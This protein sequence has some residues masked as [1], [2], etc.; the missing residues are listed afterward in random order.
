M[1]VIRAIKIGAGGRKQIPDHWVSPTSLR[2][3]ILKDPCLL[4]LKYHGRQYGFEEDPQEGSLMEYI[5]RQGQLFE[6]KWLREL[7]PEAVAASESDVAVRRFGSLMKTVELMARRIPVITKAAVWNA[8]HGVYGCQDMI[9]LASWLRK[10]FPDIASHL[11]D[12]NKDC[13]HVLDMKN[14]RG[15]DKTSGATNLKL[16]ATQIGIYTRAIGELQGVVPTHAFL[17]TPDHLFSPLPVLVGGGLGDPLPAEIAD[18]IRLHNHI[19]KHGGQ[20]RPWHDEIVAPN[21]R[22]RN[23]EAPWSGAKKK[24]LSEHMDHRPL[25]LLPGVGR[26]QAEA[27]REAGFRS[28]DDLLKRSAR[29]FDFTT[30]PGFKDAKAKQIRAVLDA[31]SNEEKKTPI[32]R[33]ELVPPRRDVELHIDYEYITPI[34][35]DMEKD[36]P[37]LRG[38]ESIFMIGIGW[39]EHGEWRFQKFAATDDTPEAEKKLLEKYIGFLREKGVIFGSIR[40]ATVC[41]GKDAVLYHW[42][43]AEVGASRRAA[44]R[45][46]LDVLNHLPWVDLAKSFRQGPIVFPGQFDFSIKSVSKALGDLCPEFATF[47]P[48]DLQAG[49]DAM[50]L[51]LRAFECGDVTNSKEFTTIAAYLEIDCANLYQ[52]LRWLRSSVQRDEDKSS[53]RTTRGRTANLNLAGGWYKK[54]LNWIK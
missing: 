12:S 23:K 34:R 41:P 1:D 42:S 31:N 36:W 38:R 11:G 5:T 13:Y 10:R 44:R 4:W 16:A 30:V 50:A 33:A 17:V 35:I 48:K 32:V 20:Y 45:T 52:I 27:L 54:S 43:P 22:N 26:E 29:H 14:Q 19:K 46:G 47:Y 49:A 40:E 15:L 7:A 18:M 3:L 39:E 8:E 53:P 25:E 9:A 37:Q 24:I 2:G 28:T 21:W 51:A 6:E